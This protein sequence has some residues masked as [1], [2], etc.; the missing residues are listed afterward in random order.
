MTFVPASTYRLQLGQ[1]VTFERVRE[2]AGYLERLGVGALYI[3]P[4]LQARSGS[5][6]GYDVT[7]P[8][9]LDP[10]LGDG[11]AFLGLPLRMAC[12][13]AKQLRPIACRV[14]TP[15]NG[16]LGKL[17]DHARDIR[18]RPSRRM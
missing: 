4:V 8:T 2:L 13:S 11:P 10:R 1:D 5:T 16:F 3:S 18:T 6:H 14:R 15:G 17:P 12:V 9:R 7:D